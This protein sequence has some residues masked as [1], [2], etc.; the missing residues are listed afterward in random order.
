MRILLTAAE[1]AEIEALVLAEAEGGR[2][3]L[4]KMIRDA[5]KRRTES[6]PEDALHGLFPAMIPGCEVDYEWFMCDLLAHAETEPSE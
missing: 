6:E 3:A 4:P 2:R 1:R 5:A